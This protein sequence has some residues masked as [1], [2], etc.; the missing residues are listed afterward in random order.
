MFKRPIEDL[1]KE[2]IAREIA[3][4]NQQRCRRLLFKLLERNIEKWWD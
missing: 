1:S 4:E 2:R 3:Y